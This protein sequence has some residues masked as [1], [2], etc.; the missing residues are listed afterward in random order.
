MKRIMALVLCAFLLMEMPA[1]ATRD[2]VLWADQVDAPVAE[3]EEASLPVDEDQQ[4][5]APKSVSAATNSGGVRIKKK[6]F[7]DERFRYYIQTELDADCDGYLSKEERAAVKVMDLSGR[8]I[9]DLGGVKYFTKLKY[10]YV[11]DN[12]LTALDLE[13]NTKLVELDVSGNRLQKLSLNKN[14][15][16]TTVNA[17]GNRLTKVSIGKCAALAWLDVSGNKLEALD[18]SANSKLAQLDVSG[19]KLKRLS[20]NKNK[21]LTEVNAED[22]QLTK[23]SV[24]KCAALTWLNVSGNK[25]EALDLSGN[26][27]LMQLYCSG[28]KLKQLSLKKNTRLQTLW[29]GDNALTALDVGK[30]AALVELAC[31]NNR[32]SR[33]N[34]TQNA[35][36]TRLYC[37]NNRL[38]KL[39]VTQNALLAVLACQGNSLVRLDAATMSEPLNRLLNDKSLYSKSDSAVSWY[40]S[41]ALNAS[42]PSSITLYCGPKIL[43]GAKNLMNHLVIGMERCDY[44]D[45]TDEAF[46]NFR[47]VNTTGMGRNA[48]YRS[49]SPIR[50]D[51]NRN[52]EVDTAAWNAGIRSAV[53][54]SE[55]RS[56]LK[57]FSGYEESYYSTINVWAK[58]LTGTALSQY[59]MDRMADAFRFIGQSEGPYLVHCI[60]GKDRTG[61]ACALLECLMGASADEVAAD[62]MLT[63]YNYYGIL[64]DTD[65]YDYIVK[66]KIDKQLSKAFGID[67]IFDEGVDLMACA[68]RF[69]GQIGLSQQEILDLR[70][71]LSV[72][73][74]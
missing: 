22:N 72:D 34:V 56:A 71:K 35:R 24:G 38:T 10:L 17:E 31:P 63:Y 57:S 13:K 46:A 55:N 26:G 44:A 6:N 54:L 23:I 52:S 14:K 65:A 68:E 74:P 45:L 28:N 62:Y 18:L 40:S 2:A 20:L 29:C 32:L 39:N 21:A 70:E 41:E 15:A 7:P 1:F 49:S 67:S 30:C 4:D 36:L 53:N 3:A 64:P 50:D 42:V 5:L 8:G 11:R 73:Y 61:L 69:L 59:N 9:E 43:Y 47:R 33:L 58:Y 66:H 27:K 37:Q 16:L 60:Y 48:L 51:V 12:A 19:N 25:L